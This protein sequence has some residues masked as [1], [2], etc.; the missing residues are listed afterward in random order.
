MRRSNLFRALAKKDGPLIKICGLKDPAVALYCAEVGV[1]L[2]GFIFYPLSPRHVDPRAV[3]DIMTPGALR[4]GV[5]V[6]QD[7]AEILDIMATARL[8]LAQL[9]GEQDLATAKAIGPERVIRVFWP[10]R[11]GFGK[12][13]DQDQDLNQVRRS[14]QDQ[15]KAQAQDQLQDLASGPSFNPDQSL[16]PSPD[17]LA[18]DLA[19]WAEFSTLFLFD[20]G[21]A[22]GGHGQKLG[23]FN[24]PTPK[25]FLLAGGL[26]PADLARLWPNAPANLR[27]FDFNSGVE[28]AKG[29]KDKAAIASLIKA[30]ARLLGLKSGHATRRCFLI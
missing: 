16:N 5:F 20:A 27:G 3:R 8:D 21:R 30:K 4:V 1:D 7:G 9:H 19:K 29:V 14:A 2:V 25:P 11:Y 22:V 6:E 17:L 28:R 24:F 23:A 12:A 18:A 13:Q 10:S 26:E 15:D